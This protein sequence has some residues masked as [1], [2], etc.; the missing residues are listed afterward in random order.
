MLA[1]DYWAGHWVADGGGS[2]VGAG[3]DVPEGMG[4]GC[5][6]VGGGWVGVAVGWTGDG[7][8]GEGW[9]RGGWVGDASIGDASAGDGWAADSRAGDG[10]TSGGWPARLGRVMLPTWASCSAGSVLL[11]ADGL[12]SGPGGS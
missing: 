6:V 5:W 4:S 12:P 7:W 11:V 9:G 10:W 8:T 2:E 1:G 3:V